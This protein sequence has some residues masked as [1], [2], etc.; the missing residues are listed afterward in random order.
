MDK[1]VENILNRITEVEYYAGR[2]DLTGKKCLDFPQTLVND[3]KYILNKQN[4]EIKRLKDQ[5]PKWIPVEERLPEDH[6]NVLIFDKKWGILI[7]WHMTWT[8]SD[9]WGTTE[10][11]RT[12]EITHWMPLPEPPK[13]GE[14]DGRT[15]DC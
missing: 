1:S 9:G 2:C 13:A 7:G 8:N 3:I 14:Q 6:E 10:P 5:Q 4:E 15:T 12:T 11:K